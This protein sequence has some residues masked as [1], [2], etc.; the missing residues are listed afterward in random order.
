[1]LLICLADRS[2]TLMSWRAP[3]GAVP[4]VPILVPVPDAMAGSYDQPDRPRSSGCGDECGIH[5]EPL[6]SAN[7]APAAFF[8]VYEG[9]RPIR[10][11]WLELPR[12]RIGGSPADSAPYMSI[13]V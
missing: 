1:M 4:V 7:V 2:G 12:S 5:V 11:T 3:A 9:G 10:V 13:S 8:S 6:R